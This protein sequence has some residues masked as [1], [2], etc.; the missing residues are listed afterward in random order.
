MAV[1][2]KENPKL[3]DL[4]KRL[5]DA[6]EDRREGAVKEL[7]ALAKAGVSATD[8][9]FLLEASA[10]KY[11]PQK[12]GIGSTQVD[13]ILAAASNP[14]ASYI[15][16]VKE[17]FPSLETS[18]KPGIAGPRAEALALLASIDDKAGALALLD[19]LEAAV[20]SGSPPELE[21]G[22]LQEKPKFPD[23][24]FPRM[25][26]SAKGP[27]ASG[28]FSLCLAYATQGAISPAQLAPYSP[29]LVDAYQPM[30]PA[31]TAAQVKPGTS[32]I[33]DESY[34]PLRE[35]AGLLLDL[36]GYFPS[37]DVEVILN[38]A[39]KLKDPK[40]A[41]FGAASLLRLG[42]N[43]DSGIWEH[44]AASPE[45]RSWLFDNLKRLGK[46]QL[47]P[48]KWATQKA[49]AEAEM[50]RWLTFPTELGRGPD[51]IELMKVVS[52]DFGPPNGVLEWYLFRFRTQPPHWSAKYGWIA[53][54]AGPFKKA[55][56][57]STAAYGDTFSAFARWDSKTP[58]QHIAYVRML[59]ARWRDHDGGADTK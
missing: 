25:L 16:I 28:V 33:W 19:L 7:E 30:R 8:G 58:E 43:V 11:P 32:W 13:L 34:A 50:V 22:E 56:A 24:Y 26:K 40:L 53:G 17:I 15:P 29:V 35:E 27:A 31:I 36:M 2:S 18:T 14:D 1:A 39:S 4:V 41:Y 20:A 12:S 44:V 48:A 54:V 37:G 21:F 5:G 46:A 10:N 38:E 57:P 3:V 59:I 55:D 52:E 51:D 23:V 42:R 9:A 6:D 47:F 49:L 45:M